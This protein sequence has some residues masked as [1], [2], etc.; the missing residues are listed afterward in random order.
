MRIPSRDGDLMP[1]SASLARTVVLA[2]AL[3]ATAGGCASGGRRDEPRGA[4]RAAAAVVFPAPSPEPRELAADQQIIQALDRLTFGARPGDVARV[5]QVGLDGW[6]AEQLQPARI[7]DPAATEALARYETLGRS[8][9]ELMRDYPPPAQLIAQRRRAEM[10][11]GATGDSVR[12]EVSAA[13]SAELR[14]ARQRAARVAQE[15][16]SAKVARAVV[17]ERQLQEVM[18]DFWENHFNVYAA[19]GPVERYYL[20]DFD[21][22]VIRPNALGKFRD[23]LGAVAKSPAMLYYL[24]NWQSTADSGRPVLESAERMRVGGRGSGLRARRDWSR[25]RRRARL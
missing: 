19:K 1:L 18:V 9:A 2:T 11:R 10:R 25:S 12:A 6:I 3:A 24:D 20:S 8:P 17:S 23:L 5:R 13:D 14:S 7:A 21:D 16:A 22:R 4:G 15:V